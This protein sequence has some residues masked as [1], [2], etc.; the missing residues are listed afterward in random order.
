MCFVWQNAGEYLHLKYLPTS[1]ITLR[2]EDIP[3]FPFMGIKLSRIN[4]EYMKGKI[5][6]YYT[7]ISINNL[8]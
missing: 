7:I 6:L 1:I 4:R 3:V 5:D 2:R 8:R